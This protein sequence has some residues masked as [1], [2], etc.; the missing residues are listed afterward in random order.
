MPQK[1]L[2]ETELQM[3]LQTVERAGSIAAAAV[4][5]DM[6]YG[7]LQNRLR[8]AKQLL[9]PV[10][11]LQEEAQ[12]PT[13]PDEDLPVNDILNHLESAFLK[14]SEHEA[15]KHWFKVK[16]KSDAPY[17]LAVIGDPHLGVHCNIP[18]LRRDVEILATTEGVGA[19]NIG[20]TVDNWG[21]R[22]I[23]LYADSDIS[24]Q[25][26]RRLAQ[27]FLNK[28]EDD[29]AGIPW[30][31]WLHGNHDTMHTEFS[32]YLKAINVHQIPMLDWRA[33]FK[34]CFPSCE[35]KIDAAHNHK[36]TS[37][38]NPL[39]GQK[40]ASLWDDQAD[41]YIAG[42]HHTWAIS[43]EEAADNRVITMARARGYKWDDEYGKR[44]GFRQDNF[45]ATI[46][47]VIDPTASPETR[48]KPFADLKEG[49]EF[50]RWKRNQFKN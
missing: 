35:V 46:L 8:R 40:R 25:T 28:K 23:R 1:P 22:L 6:P 41:I 10:R 5:L 3:A 49:A 48:V 9:Q 4:E 20:D 32:T 18:L 44:G 37:I 11:H 13:F 15:A 16:I 31:V 14:K 2:T 26:E 17:G 12:L 21:G 19:V 45:G 42:H 27:W 34:L 38:Y 29:G 36:G 43:Q 33:N 47:F 7:T 39:Q 30:V 24:R 50:L